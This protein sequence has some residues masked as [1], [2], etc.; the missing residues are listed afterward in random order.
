MNKTGPLVFKFGG[1]SVASP[2]AI[3]AVVKIVAA[4]HGERLVVVSATAGTTDALL[5]ASQQ[6]AGGDAM[7]A[8]ATIERLSEQHRNLIAD[9]LGVNGADVLGEVVDLTERTIALLRLSLIHI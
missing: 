2:P 3:T 1:T 5:Q 8:Q 6:A 4:E 7:A 9:L